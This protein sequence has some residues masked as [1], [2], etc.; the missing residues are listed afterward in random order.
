VTAGERRGRRPDF[1][2]ACLHRV[3]RAIPDE[4]VAVVDGVGEITFGE[5]RE[6]SGRVASALLARGL[7]GARVAVVAAEEDWLDFLAA[8][9]GGYRAGAT[10]VPLN[11]RWPAAELERVARRA[12]VAAALLAGAGA[13]AA[14][15]GLRPLTDRVL[16]L[17]A[18]EGERRAAVPD[19]RPGPED[20]ACVVFTS[21]TSGPRKGVQ[22]THAHLAAGFGTPWPPR[23][24]RSRFL[25]SV[26]VGTI[27]AQT[28][29][30]DAVGGPLV[31][32]QPR[33]D[34]VRCCEL[35]EARRITA[36]GLVP[37]SAAAVV[38]ALRSGRYDVSSV[39]S[40]VSSSA[41]L[42]PATFHDLAAA[43]PAARVHNV[44][45]LTE[46]P[47]LW[48]TYGSGPPGSLGRPEPGTEV[49]IL[50]ERG[51]ALPPGEVGEI[52]LRR[53]DMPSR[54]P[55][56][57]APDRGQPAWVATG[58][59]GY[60]DAGGQVY[61]V[62]RKDDVIVSAGHK[63]PSVEV[64]SALL[65]HP[66]V[67]QAAVVGLPHPLLGQAVVAAVRVAGEVT[68][69]ELQRH[70]AERLA[71]P[72]R[73]SRVLIR[74]ELPVNDAGKVVKRL[75]RAE[76]S[77]AGAGAASAPASGED[78]E[79]L[80]VEVWR[81]VLA[82]GDVGPRDSFLALGGHSL[83]ATMAALRIGERLGLDVPLDVV[84]EA[85]TAAELAAGLRQAAAAGRLTP[86]RRIG[87]AGS[88]GSLTTAGGMSRL[89]DEER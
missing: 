55:L 17:A 78:L 59:L 75:L 85:D 41:P 23:G 46:G 42:P 63:V 70:C 36:L 15:P 74:P 2:T 3:A 88:D 69:G 60:V 7:E 40:V 81:D 84:L 56:D 57:A 47:T 6:R 27:A 25:T 73:P 21:A 67:V 58:D 76:L 30:H 33:F 35:I 72:Q 5:L 83:L 19:A 34:P 16:R 65:Q 61:F 62:D 18:L 11:A 71:P 48:T 54:R 66:L 32:V 38:H 89:P 53:H 52:H 8:C 45:S 79:A 10:L 64:E 49:R 43:F 82:L 39:R 28:L 86:V 50:S 4:L 24:P 51:E 26:S 68:P 20:V 44:Y 31:V 14:A 87:R 22:L 13:D 29:V 77:R 1:V 37:S 12:G 80:V 9:Y